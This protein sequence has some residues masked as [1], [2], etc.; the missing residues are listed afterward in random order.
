MNW[1]LKYKIGKLTA[2]S[3]ISPASLSREDSIYCILDSQYRMRELILDINTQMSAFNVAN[4]L[5]AVTA[6][7]SRVPLSEVLI[8]GCRIQTIAFSAFSNAAVSFF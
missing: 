4:L 7:N 3:Q 2:I 5:I 6:E 1:M 8:T